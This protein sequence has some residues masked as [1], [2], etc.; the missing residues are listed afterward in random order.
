MI[1]ETINITLNASQQSLISVGG[2]PFL[3]PLIM[4]LAANFFIVMLILIASGQA[5]KSGA[6]ALVFT[7]FVGLVLT[8]F[9]PAFLV[10]FR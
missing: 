1:N 7:F 10:M 5:K 4:F 3:V 8:L 9:F 2:N 6:L